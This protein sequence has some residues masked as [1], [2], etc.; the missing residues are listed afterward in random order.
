M[1]D[2]KH[3]PGEWE[4]RGTMVV[5]PPR[6][7]TDEFFAACR[8]GE[9]PEPITSRRICLADPSP[10]VTESEAEANARLI[11]AAPN[12][13]SACKAL[14]DAPHHEH[15]ATRLNDQEM[16]A[17]DAIRAAVAKAESR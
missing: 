3:T 6:A 9:K 12:L 15:F 5:T 14:I 16:A 11:A 8:R 1:S 10:Y 17:V 4:A 7:V 2:A 13:F